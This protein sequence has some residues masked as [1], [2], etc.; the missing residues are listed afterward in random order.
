V[1]HLFLINKIECQKFKFDWAK[2]AIGTQDDYP[3]IVKA[4]N[5][6]DVYMF[7]DYQSNSIAFDRNLLINN[8]RVNLFLVK[9]NTK[10][11]VLWTKGFSGPDIDGVSGMVIDHNNNITITIDGSL[12][13]DIDSIRIDCSKSTMIVVQ[14]N[15]QGKIN[16]IKHYSCDKGISGIGGISCDS[17]NNIYIS[18]VNEASIYNEKGNKIFSFKDSLKCAFIIKINKIGEMVWI[19]SI[20]CPQT[21]YITSTFID[22]NDDLIIYGNFYGKIL[23]LDNLEIIN[24]SK[25]NKFESYYSEIYFAKIL[26]SGKAKYIKSISGNM[27]ELTSFNQIMTDSFNNI[28]LTGLFNSDT[29]KLDDITFKANS[30]TENNY[31]IFYCKYDS[32][33]NLVW[34]NTLDNGESLAE[35][36]IYIEQNGYFYLIGNYDKNAFKKEKY[37]LENFGSDDIFVLFGDS[38]GNI[39]P[40]TI[41]FG[42]NKSDMIGHITSDQHNIF[43]IGY[44]RSDTIN[45]GK[46]LIVNSNTDGSSDLFIAKLSKDSINYIRP[47]VKS[48]SI[49]VHPNPARSFCKIIIIFDMT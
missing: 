10:G 43:I 8:G 17:E 9:Y 31:D 23:Y 25:K 22:K 21:I 14:L 26:K 36:S 28:Y 45:I 2:S 4:D 7:G 38:M 46:N 3:R 27:D 32:N 41:S 18:G 16:W 6:G 40:N 12:Y 34:A 20:E 19:K 49:S 24:Y 33:G 48:K 44:F 42:G 35:T 11:K 37:S 47:I 15:P 30:K 13:L 5:Y 39:L 1:I 29:L